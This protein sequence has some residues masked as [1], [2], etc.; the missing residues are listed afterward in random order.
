MQEESDSM[1]VA[2]SSR[3]L[4]ISVSAAAQACRPPPPPSYPAVGRTWSIAAAWKPIISC[5]PSLAL[6]CAPGG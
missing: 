5:K 6:D 3:E 1:D 4:D 2:S